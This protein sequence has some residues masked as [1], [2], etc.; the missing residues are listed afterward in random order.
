VKK[1]IRNRLNARKR[2][3]ESRLDKS[4]PCDFTKPMFTATNI[5]YEIADRVRGIA[6]GGIGAFHLLAQRIGLVDAIDRDLHVLKLHMGYHESDHVR[7]FADNALCNGDCLQDI[8]LRRN[9][10]NF[11]DALGAQRIPDPTTE[12]DFCRR[13]NAFQVDVLQDSFDGVRIKLW[14][15]QPEDFFDQATI[16][17][18]GTLVATD[19]QCK[20]GIGIAYDGTW[21]YH[22]L[23]PISAGGKWL[24]FLAA[25]C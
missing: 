22:P 7:N 11:L 20:E 4:K 17:A 6:Y 2:Q 3:I 21:G 1:S 15:R 12:G 9:D 8:E 14:K 16:D 10:V 18:D 19:A 23:T 24:T 13:F 5:Q 25:R